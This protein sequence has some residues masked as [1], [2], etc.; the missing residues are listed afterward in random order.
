MKNEQYDLR[1]DNT[2]MASLIA[3]EKKHNIQLL[4]KQF[5]DV[6]DL[7]VLYN[8]T[9]EGIVQIC[10]FNRKK[11]TS[12][13]DVMQKAAAGNN[14]IVGDDCLFMPYDYIKG[15]IPLIARQTSKMNM[16]TMDFNVFRQRWAQS[17]K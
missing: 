15:I 13:F 1:T 9:E 6:N 12:C 5:S 8:T 11:V 4:P 14:N 17:I 3:L 10:F 2:L 16:G 7:G